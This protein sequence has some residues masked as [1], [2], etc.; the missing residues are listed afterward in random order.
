M[1][2]NYNVLYEFLSFSILS[3]IFYQILHVLKNA[4]RDMDDNTM[5]MIF[6]AKQ[7]THI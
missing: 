3:T 1:N 4:Y 6:R 5:S 7:E 2:I